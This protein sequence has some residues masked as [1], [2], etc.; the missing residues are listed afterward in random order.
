MTR[1][2]DPRDPAVPDHPT[3]LLSF[4]AEDSSGGHA[5][6]ADVIRDLLLVQVHRDG[7]IGNGMP[8]MQPLDGVP[9]VQPGRKQWHA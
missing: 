1:Q 7:K 6:L 8:V 4:G 9:E 2:Q 3:P 5:R